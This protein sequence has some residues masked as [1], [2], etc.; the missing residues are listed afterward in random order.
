MSAEEAIIKKIREI[1]ISGGGKEA[2]REAY[3]LAIQMKREGNYKSWEDL[4][5]D[6]HKDLT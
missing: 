1:K 5:I 3:K 2:T 6:L 4:L